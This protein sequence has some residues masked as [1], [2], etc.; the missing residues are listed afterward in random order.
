MAPDRSE[1]LDDDKLGDE[2][3]PERPLGVE[4]YGTTAQEERVAE[5]MDERDHRY[6]D[7]EPAGEGTEA[8]APGLLDQGPDDDEKDMVADT[9]EV[10]HEGTPEYDTAADRV[11]RSAEEEAVHVIEE[12]DATWR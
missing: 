9:D 12:E 6:E 7:E 3:P 8:V 11:P 5:P 10:P 2:Y 1:Q 4:E